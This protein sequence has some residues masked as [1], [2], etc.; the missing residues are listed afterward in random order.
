MP[1]LRCLTEAQVI[2]ATFQPLREGDCMKWDGTGHA[3]SIC[4]GTSDV[5]TENM[6]HTHL[7]GAEEEDTV[8]QDNNR[9]HQ[10]H[11]VQ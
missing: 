9:T 11:D 3:D 2:M 7:P 4:I 10:A 1:Y 5:C 6:Q 8:A